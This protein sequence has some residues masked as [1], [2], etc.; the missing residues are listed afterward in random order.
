MQ[1]FVMQ[2]PGVLGSLAGG[3]TF[4]GQ[5]VTLPPGL[6]PFIGLRVPV[7]MTGGGSRVVTIRDVVVLPAIGAVICACDSPTPPPPPPAV[8]P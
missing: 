5:W 7:E 1:I 8:A 2:R 6:S 4:A 3:Q